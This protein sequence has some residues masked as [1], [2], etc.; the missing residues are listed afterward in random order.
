MPRPWRGQDVCRHPAIPSAST[1]LAASDICQTSASPGAAAAANRQAE[2]VAAQNTVS[3][4][5]RRRCSPLHATS[6]PRIRKSTVT[7]RR[8]ALPTFFGRIWGGSA[9]SVTA[10][11]MA[12]AYNPS[13]S[14][15][16]IQVQGVK[17]WLIPNC[18]PTNGGPGDCAAGG[19]FVDNIS[20]AIQNNGSFVGK[21]DY[22][23]S[24]HGRWCADC[25]RAHSRKSQLFSCDS[26]DSTAGTHLSIYERGLLRAGG[27]RRLSR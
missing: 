6:R 27:E 18:D 11:A 9:N 16:P 26:T 19:R 8:T 22:P 10:T 24:C 20:G 2:A 14:A 7:I 15:A 4:D 5:S 12:E 25:Q 3:R 13:G 21:N 23:S 17:P 1:T